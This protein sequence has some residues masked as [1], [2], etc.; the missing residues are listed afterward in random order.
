MANY[1]DLWHVERSSGIAKTDPGA[2]PMSVRK[3]DAI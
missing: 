2:T 3:R 1:H